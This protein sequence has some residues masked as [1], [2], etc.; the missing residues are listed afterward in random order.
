MKR[1]IFNVL[2]II[3][4]LLV[5][6]SCTD[7]SMVPAEKL[8]IYTINDFHGALLED[9]GKYGVARLGEYIMN[10]KKTKPNETIVL[11][12][13]DMFQGS[14]LSYYSHGEDVVELMN[15]IEFDAM[16]IGNHEF[17]WS[18]DTILEYRDGNKKNGEA[19]FPFLGAN[20]IQKSTRDLPEYVEPY[21]VIERGG[22]TIGIIGYIG[23]G[24]E[25]D[26]ATQMVENY[27]FSQPVDVIG[28]YAE[29]LRTKEDCDVV[30]ALGHDGSEATNSGLASLTGDERI[31]AIVNGHLH[32]ND[33]DM[34]TSADGR[35]IPVVQ[36]GSSGE[37]VGVISF[38][39]N[40]ETKTLSNPGVITVE[41]DK[42]IT[43]NQKILK[44]VEDLEEETA[45]FFG[46]VI[47]KA[48]TKITVF[49]VRQ[50]GPNI[51]Q[52]KMNV[53]VAFANTGG[54]RA[55]AF[56]I[57]ALEDVTV[58]K[59]YQIMPFDNIVKTCKLKGADIKKVLNLSGMNVSQTIERIDG[60]LYING[61]E[62]LDDEYY[63][64]ATIDY[65]FD[66]P[67]YPFLKGIDITND[68]L[69]YRDLMIEVIEELTA[70]NQKW[71]PKN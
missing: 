10:A 64:V 65:V 59:I 1:K 51:L 49:D 4:L 48:E 15:M 63:S 13:G 44:F 31:D 55:D 34:I 47:G 45:P 27:E 8:T 50:W 20:I 56:P 21:T 7:K 68:G 40:Q 53:D 37:Y 57:E 67:E 25:D 46:R 61:K 3:F 41:M 62:L 26:I 9:D 12:A 5:M 11:S 19:D 38:S 14:G 16:A 58:A 70:S 35:K 60:K 69:L 33:V 17:D 36:A 54:I 24:L 22:L 2:V 6:T 18:L 43:P 52:E 23:Y 71:N 39:V 66:K 29:T 30:I 32:A 28:D 42:K